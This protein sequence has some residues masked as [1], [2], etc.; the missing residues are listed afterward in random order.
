VG[1]V[2]EGWRNVDYEELR[3]VY[4]STNIIRVMKSMMS[5]LT[6]RGRHVANSY[7]ILAGEQD[8]AGEDER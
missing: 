3:N 5:S 6:E 4:S 1:K 2:K 7:R 8:Y